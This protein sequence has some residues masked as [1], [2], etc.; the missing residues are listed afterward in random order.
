M[1]H[2]SSIDPGCFLTNIAFLCTH[3]HTE[4][5]VWLGRRRC[6]L[7]S[8]WTTPVSLHLSATMFTSC[9]LVNNSIRP[10]LVSRWLVVGEVVFYVQTNCWN[11]LPSSLSE[12]G[13]PVGGGVNNSIV[14][15]C[16][17]EP[18]VPYLTK[19]T[20][21]NKK[22][23]EHI[24]HFVCSNSR[25]RQEAT[26]LLAKRSGYCTPNSI[27][28]CFV[29]VQTPRGFDCCRHTVWLTS[30]FYYCIVRHMGWRWE[31]FPYLQCDLQASTS[32]DGSVF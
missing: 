1:Y 23:L 24:H 18:S 29:A 4:D 17:R 11:N 32:L 6:S 14:G 9:V 13:S 12:S 25:Q 2:L 31:Q 16:H 26:L 28:S 15:K 5:A 7:L 8:W 22:N 30:C 20:K 3:T 19:W 27:S 10:F 21:K